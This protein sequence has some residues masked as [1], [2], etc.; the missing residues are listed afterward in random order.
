MNKVL[1]TALITVLAGLVVALG[2]FVLM[3]SFA[4][5]FQSP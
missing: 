2:M 5:V 3:V 1:T 4:A